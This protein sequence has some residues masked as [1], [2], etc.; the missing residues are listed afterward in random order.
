MDGISA[1]W[2][3]GGCTAIGALAGSL[4]GAYAVYAPQR[5]ANKQQD[6]EQL[7]NQRKYEDDRVA[8]GYE[9]QIA[10]LTNRVTTLET[11][12]AAK[13]EKHDAEVRALANQHLE[14]V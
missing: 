9:E 14:C 12:M 10:L 8:A 6:N 5:R 7:T 1:A 13:D 2:L 3:A 11:V 4:A